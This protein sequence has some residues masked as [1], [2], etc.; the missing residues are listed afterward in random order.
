M[1]GEKNEGKEALINGT[2]AD[3]VHSLLTGKSDIMKEQKLRL[4]WEPNKELR[5]WLVND[6]FVGDLQN[7]GYSISNDGL[8]E[9]ENAKLDLLHRIMAGVYVELW[10]KVQKHLVIQVTE[11]RTTPGEVLKLKYGTV[12]TPLQGKVTLENAQSFASNKIKG[13][14]NARRHGNE[15][16]PWIDYNDSIRLGKREYTL[17]CEVLT[18]SSDRVHGC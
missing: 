8:S 13:G 15:I 16:R 3:M 9:E 18:L 14:V 6:K 10:M 17:R 7:P 1:E 4:V 12:C 2:T 11:S 5:L